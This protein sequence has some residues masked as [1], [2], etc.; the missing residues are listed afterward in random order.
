MY[1]KLGGTFGY[2]GWF[3]SLKEGRSFATN[4][5]MLFLTVNGKEPGSTLRVEVGR[6]VKA[7]VRAEALSPRA[8]DRLEILFRGKVIKTVSGSRS[9]ARLV[10]D[11]ESSFDETGWLAARC[12][13]PAAR[14]IRFAHTSP[15]Y[16]Q[17]GSRVTKAPEDARFFIEWIDREIDFCQGE[18]GFRD[19]RH[20]EAML[21]L[22]RKARTVYAKLA[23][24]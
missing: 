3:R 10:A 1:V 17:V 12:F 4:G 5:P 14:A 16:I 2:S 8:L 21:E 22:F 11:F 23:R 9:E 24:E 13:E 18:K 7:R 20:R 6:A 19:P 15:V